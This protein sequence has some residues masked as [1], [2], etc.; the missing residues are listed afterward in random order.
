MSKFV[1]DVETTEFD[2]TKKRHIV[3]SFYSLESLDS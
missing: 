1:I 3:A 2:I